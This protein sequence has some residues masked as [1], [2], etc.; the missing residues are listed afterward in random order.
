MGIL[1][2]RLLIVLNEEPLDS[3]DF[4]IAM[5]MLENYEKLAMLTIEQLAFLCH[6]SK[7]K[8]SKFTRRLGFSDYAELRDTI[9]NHSHSSYS[10]NRVNIPFLETHPFLDYCQ[11]MQNDICLL[12]NS[13]SLTAIDDL[14]NDLIHYAKVA[15]FGLLYSESAAIDLQTKLA[16]NNKYIYTSLN[17][18]KQTEYIKNAKE[19]TL[20]VVFSHSGDYLLKQQMIDGN[21]QKSAFRRTKAKIVLITGN[22]D[23]AKHQM[24]DYAITYQTSTHLPTHSII[25]PLISDYITYRYWYFLKQII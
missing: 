8:I 16:M 5:V 19:D 23:L 15:A 18:V 9:P 21:I 6:V 24:V 17:D 7:S 12:V 2:N 22:K 20:I 11:I 13:I 14:A 10:Y 25:F 4:H 1:L 3:T